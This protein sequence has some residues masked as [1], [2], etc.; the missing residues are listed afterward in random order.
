MWGVLTQQPWEVRGSEPGPPPWAL[1][2]NGQP[3]NGSQDRHRV[4][5]TGNHLHL[6]LW[7]PGS[8]FVNGL[9]RKDVGILG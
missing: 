9:D 7:W 8:K 6:E 1:G 5:D 3:D 4:M 2:Q